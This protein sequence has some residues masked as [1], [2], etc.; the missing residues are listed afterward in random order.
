MRTQSGIVALV[1]SIV[2]G[3]L[4][5]VITAGAI[6]IMSSELRQASDFDQSIKAY[7]AAESGL[8]D[9]I[10]KIRTD[11]NAGVPLET[12][13]DA[14]NSA[15]NK[16]LP[17]NASDADLSGDGGGDYT[18]AS[19][20]Y[21]CQIVESL[22]QKIE[23]V[24]REEEPIQIDLS[25]MADSYNAIRISWNQRGAERDPQIY[26]AIPAG[27]PSNDTADKWAGV[28]P[29]VMELA[30]IKYPKA[31]EFDSTEI[32]LQSY[33]AKPT[34]AL[35]RTTIPYDP[36]FRQN[37]HDTTCT[38]SATPGNYDC[39]ATITGINDENTNRFILRFTARYTSAHYKVEVLQGNIP[40]TIPGAQMTIDVTGKAG[41]VYRRVRA[42]VPIGAPAPRNPVLLANESICKVF[43][44]T[45]IN[46][47][48]S[49]ETG[50]ED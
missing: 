10:A 7:Y 19:V 25:S 23:G 49:T 42:T 44:V 31:S 13:L 8:E 37:P 14:E 21:T 18:R 27:F 47:T 40:R 39:V 20:S 15:A 30:L 26:G 32:R 3:L 48:A 1:T 41:D 12:I 28:Y 16:C 38:P 29:A 6:S 33:I 9:A 35:G 45:R 11:L 43:E 50:C 17:F 24:A 34:S 4:L 22:T 46:N 2:V 36:G 5:V